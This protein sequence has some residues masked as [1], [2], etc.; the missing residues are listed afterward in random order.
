MMWEFF[1][2]QFKLQIFFDVC[3]DH[4]EIILDALPQ[5]IVIH[6]AFYICFLHT[7]F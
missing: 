1:L 5:I 2:M 6:V 4:I 7:Y 3:Y